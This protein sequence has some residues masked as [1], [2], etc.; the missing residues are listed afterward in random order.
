MN[1]IGDIG[2]KVRPLNYVE[3]GI[4]IELEWPSNYIVWDLETTGIDL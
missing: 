3:R 2:A 1:N 4:A